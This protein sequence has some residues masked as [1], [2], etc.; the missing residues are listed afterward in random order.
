MYTWPNGEH[1]AFDVSRLLRRNDIDPT[2]LAVPPT[3]AEFRQSELPPAPPTA[4]LSDSELTEF[5]LRPTARTDKADPSAPKT[6]LLVANH[7][8]SLRYLTIDGAPV[9]RLPPGAEQL[10]LGLRSGKYQVTARDF[11]GSEDAVTKSIEVPGHFTLGD[12]T[13]K[14]H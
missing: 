8:E 12:D 7:S 11:F 6:G 5:R 9:A 3:G 4:L 2:L 14:P 13:E 1:F 10:L